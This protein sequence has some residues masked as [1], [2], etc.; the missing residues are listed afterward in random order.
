[1]RM[2]RW[3]GERESGQSLVEFAM[4][5]PLLLV[6]FF[7]IID[8]GRIYQRNVSLTNAVREGARLGSVGA[9][10]GEI[11]ARVADTAS[12]LTPT[13]VVTLASRPGES[14][15]VDST[16]TVQLITPLGAMLNP[17][18]GGS[19]SNTFVLKAKADMCLE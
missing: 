2:W 13:T 16:A 3:R 18:G 7:A 9:T 11:Q 8:F 12:G 19:M 10:T 5:L 14:V 17:I 15:V 1:M 6:I 4:V